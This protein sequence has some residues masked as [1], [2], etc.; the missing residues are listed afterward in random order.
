MLTEIMAS[1]QPQPES[2]MLTAARMT[3]VVVAEVPETAGRDL[4][5]EQSV[6]GTDVELVG[7]SWDGNE[8][9]LISACRDADVVL[10]DY[11]PLTRTVIEQLQRCKLIC[12]AAT[13][14]DSIDLEAAAD[15]SISVC[16][17]DEYCTDEV[18]DHVILLML[19][20]CRRLAEY[21]DQVQRQNLWQFDSLTGL[22]RMRDMTLGIVGFGKIGQAVARR[23]RG[24]GMTVMAHDHHP[25][26]HVAA[27]LD[28]QICGLAE[29]FAA[30]DIVSLNCGLSADNEYLIDANAFRQMN[31]KPILINCARGK[32]VDEVALIDA[33]DSGQIS[34]AGLDVLSDERPDLRTSKFTGRNNVI[35]TP[36]IAFYSDASMLK[37]RKISASN[38]RNF[39]DGKHENVR[40]YIYHATN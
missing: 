31:R 2:D 24:F 27:D 5:V 26:E 19:A 29:L 22:A 17:I 18:A 9:L 15:A 3:R 34:A 25:N 11:A 30:T 32:L 16:A 36:H 23:A 8:E 37:S 7:Y 6:L 28:V 1:R 40:Q 35:L 12:V 14:S 38:I 20:L 13:G 21:H 4:S 39:L 10:T 33:L